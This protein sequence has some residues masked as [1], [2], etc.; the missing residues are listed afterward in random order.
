M[1]QHSMQ[2]ISGICADRRQG[3]M[4]SAH[5][6]GHIV[7]QVRRAENNLQFVHCHVRQPMHPSDVELARSQYTIPNT[8]PR[9]LRRALHMEQWPALREGN[10]LSL[11]VLGEM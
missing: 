9:L 6:G 10:S 5:C 11:Q 8:L 7:R 3:S 1:A 2:R 4:G